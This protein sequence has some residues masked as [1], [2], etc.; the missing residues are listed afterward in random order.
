MGVGVEYCLS[1][2]PKSSQAGLSE[3]QAAT[4]TANPATAYNI[5]H[6]FVQL[7]EGDWIVQMVGQA[8]IQIAAA[9]GHKTINFTL[10]RCVI[11]T[12]FTG[13]FNQRDDV[14]LLK[15]HLELLGAT[16]VVTYDELSDKSLR[17]KV[18]TWTGGKDIR[19]GLN[20]VSGKT[21]ILMA[22]L[23][24]NN[25]HIVSYGVMSREPLSHSRR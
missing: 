21:T 23:L 16:Y 6:D 22:R 2:C 10:D 18:K 1:G 20:C 13:S 14:E 19:L 15:Q 9:K 5:V 8:V 11:F 25:A 12:T 7:V 4:I 17:T 3:A 24:G